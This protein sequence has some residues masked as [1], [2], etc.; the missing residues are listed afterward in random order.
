MG[1]L[2][3]VHQATPWINSFVLAGGKDKFGNL[4][5]RICLDP[6]NHNK[7]IVY[8]PYHFKTPEDIP[9]LLV[10]AYVMTVCNCKKGYWH[11]ELDKASSFLTTF[12]TELG[13]FHYTVMPFGVT[14]AG[15]FFSASLMRALERSNKLL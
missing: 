6:T 7:A 11:Q 1:V 12:K 14:V 13:R 15:D 8:E 9:H 4:K 3:P 5:L 10:E 2:K